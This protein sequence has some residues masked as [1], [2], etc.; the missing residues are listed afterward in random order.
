MSLIGLIL[1][2][3]VSSDIFSFIFI[4][5]I[6]KYHVRIPGIV[7]QRVFTERQD[8]QKGDLLFQIDP[9]PLQAA[10]L[11]ILAILVLFLLLVA[12]YER[13]SIRYP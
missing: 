10:G 13:W 8:M 3:F 1:T 12:L 5:L 2:S 9:T 7:L 6:G 11:F 4:S